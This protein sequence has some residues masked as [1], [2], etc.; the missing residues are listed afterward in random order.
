MKIIQPK[1]AKLPWVMVPMNLSTRNGLCRQARNDDA[2]P[3]GLDLIWG[4]D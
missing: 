3:L 2:T 1:V 4:I